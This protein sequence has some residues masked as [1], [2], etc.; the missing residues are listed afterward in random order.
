[1]YKTILLTMIL[2]SGC[3]EKNDGNDTSNANDTG[4]LTVTDTGDSTSG[5]S[6]ITD[7]ST[8][9]DT[10]QTTPTA[11]TQDFGVAGPY[12]VL[13]TSE[14]VTLSNSCTTDTVTNKPQGAPESPHVILVH[15]FSRNQGQMT[16][17]AE[18]WASWGIPV[19]TITLCNNWILSNDPDQDATDMAT[20]SDHLGGGPVIY[21][22]HSAGGVRSVLAGSIDI[23]TVA[24]LGLDLVDYSDDFFGGDYVGE[25]VAANMNIPIF[26]LHGES[27]ECNSSDSGLGVYSAANYSTVLRVSEAD[28]CDF[29]SPTDALCTTFCQSGNN[30]FN[31]EEISKTILSLTTGFLLWQ[32]GIDPLGEELWV[33]GEPAY[34][35]LL[36]TGAITRL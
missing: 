4:S 9:T 14:S 17:I 22:G 19:S 2:T 12:N 6:E 32:T 35:N 34:E 27:T 13:T 25:Q 18:H 23:D 26:G 33:V 21:A 29:E 30:S 7:T 8:S 15:G 1:M 5:T 31:D 3:A 20:F 28:H 24:V 10:G 16:N 36:S 11:P